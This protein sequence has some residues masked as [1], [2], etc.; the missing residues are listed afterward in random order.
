M[1]L[2]GLLSGVLVA[3]A[4]MGLGGAQAEIF[5]PWCAHY[6]DETGSSNCGFDTREQCEATVRGTGGICSEN[7]W[8]KPEPAAVPAP[9][10][11]QPSRPIY[12]LTARD[13]MKTC[14]FGADDQKLAGV[15]RKKFISRCMANI[16]EPRGP[17]AAAGS[18]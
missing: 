11:S 7:P 14:Q 5:L 6:A 4:G 17:A 16:D 1:R 10:P 9:Q 15:A 18:K 12:M 3:A 13:K 8:Y 2:F